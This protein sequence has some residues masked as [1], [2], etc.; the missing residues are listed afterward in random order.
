MERFWSKVDKSGDCW[1]WRGSVNPQGYGTFSF[2]GKS[3]GA[4]RVSYLLSKGEIGDGLCVCHTCDN[5]PC[6]NPD[7]LWLGTQADNMRDMGSKN[8][9]IMLEKCDEPLK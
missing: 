8:F 7:H 1:L 5:P 6:V 4:H 2:G 3:R 9:R